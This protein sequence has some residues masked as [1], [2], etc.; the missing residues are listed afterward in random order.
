MFLVS[1]YDYDLPP[2]RIAQ[3]PVT[4]RDSSRLLRLDRAR[5]GIS[6]HRFYDLP[7]L[8]RP[9]DLLVV[10][11]TR[12]VPARLE[13]VKETGGRAGAL[14]LDYPGVRTEKGV[15]CRCMVKASGRLRPGTRFLFEDRLSASVVDAADGLY[16]LCF[17]C[18]GDFDQTLFAVGRTPLPPY[19]TRNRDGAPCDDRACYQT[20]YADRDG[21]VAAPTAGLHFTSDVLDR[22]AEKSISTAPVTLH[23]GHGTFLP[24]RVS[25]IRDHA[26]HSERFEVPAATA[27]AI[28]ATRRAGGRVVGVGTT[29]VRT[30]EYVA[31][32]CG[33]IRTFS[34]ACDLFIYPGYNFQ[35]I[36]AMITNFHLPRSTLLMLVSAFAGR[37]E[38][39]AAYE[40][41]IQEKYRFYSYGDA[42]LIE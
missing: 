4:Q 11:N 41:A 16:T 23:V 42:M 14:I 21:A 5:D 30:L 3:Q 7:D 8:L 38:I 34:G 25:D 39:L 17:S 36:D 28:N 15:I 26:M 2:D 35:S 19:I 12:V 1:D 29:V 13:G 6:H 22:L 24:V 32:A 18:D 33:E 20:V 9:A 27:A 10:N 31:R 37:K 40:A